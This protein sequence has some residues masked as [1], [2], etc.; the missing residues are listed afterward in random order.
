MWQLEFDREPG[1]YI[2][3][4]H[5]YN[6]AVLIALEDLALNAEGIPAEGCT[7]IEPGVYLWEVADHQVVYQRIPGPEGTPHRLHVLILKP[8]A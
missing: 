5:P 8:K 2:I 1:N 3:D 4:S 6:E 7:Q